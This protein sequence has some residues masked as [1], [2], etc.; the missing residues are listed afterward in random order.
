MT[1]EAHAWVREQLGLLAAVAA[2]GLAVSAA[3]CY[4]RAR[5]LPSRASAAMHPAHPPAI[6]EVRR[7]PAQSSRTGKRSTP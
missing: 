2:G 5:L 6:V 4:V 3:I 1:T 7:S